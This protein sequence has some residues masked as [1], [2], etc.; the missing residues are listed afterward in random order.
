MR[1]PVLLA[2]LLV[3]LVLPAAA[4]GETPSGPRLATVELIEAKG[5]KFS[6]D[7]RPPTMALATVDPSTGK[8]QRFLE[9]KLGAGKRLVPSP[10]HPPAW[11][12]DG[13]LMAFAAYDG[14]GEPEQ[15]KIFVAS[16]DGSDARLIPGTRG[17]SQPVFSPDGFTLAFSR[18]RF[19]SNVKPGRLYAN[20]YSSTT[21][22][23]VDLRGGKPRRLTRWR[24]G[25]YNTPGSFTADGTGLLL[26]KEDSN[27]EGSR[28]VQ[29]G[30]ADVSSR[31]I[32]EFASEPAV[33]P[34]GSQIAF[35]GY[36]DRD[37]VEAE[38]NHDYLAGEL[39]VAAAD[40][41]GIR[42]LSRSEDVL[43]SAPSWDPSG[44]RIAYVQFRADTSFVPGLG[45]LFPTGNALMQ[46]NPDGSC[47]KNIL[48]Q[49]RVAF[50]GAAWQ[51]GPGREAGPI[52]C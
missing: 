14:G 26:T 30:L 7:D 13:S 40:G 45:L 39:Y 37:L 19:R 49:P 9:A 24:N 10:F 15:D 46:V 18:T 6:E 28:I 48:S 43:E 8:Q 2:L 50:Y 22:W 35:V 27:L 23:I 5:P 44:Q 11:S 33:S 16:S 47:R 42:R 20:F 1:A 36:L 12:P 31:E 17:G 29:L 25:L 4:V 34:D 21:T 41:T 38:E 51:P 32:L 3:S 52:R